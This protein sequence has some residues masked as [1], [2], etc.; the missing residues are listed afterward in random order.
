MKYIYFF[1]SGF[2]SSPSFKMQNSTNMNIIKKMKM[3]FVY[4][5]CFFISLYQYLTKTIRMLGLYYFLKYVYNENEPFLFLATQGSPRYKIVQPTIF[6][7][8]LYPIANHNLEAHKSWR[9]EKKTYLQIVQCSF[10][11]SFLL[12]F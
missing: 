8:F 3:K 4:I 10:M 5:N 2:S 1:K 9:K 7:I 11:K 6:T 12:Q